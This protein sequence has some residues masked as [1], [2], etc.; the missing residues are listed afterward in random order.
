MP[1]HSALVP[2]T[3][4]M[5]VFEFQD[6]DPTY[7]HTNPDGTIFPGGI[8]V[9]KL[10]QGLSENE[11]KFIGPSG[12]IYALSV[13]AWEGQDPEKT[14]LQMVFH[15]TPLFPADIDPEL[16]R[17][18]FSQPS[19]PTSSP[20]AVTDK[21]NS[22]PSSLRVRSSPAATGSKRTSDFISCSDV[23]GEHRVKL[24]LSKT[25]S[26][27]VTADI[28]L[29]LPEITTTDVHCP[30]CNE[31]IRF[32]ETLN[33]RIQHGIDW[34]GSDAKIQLIFEHPIGVEETQIVPEG[35]PFVVHRYHRYTPTS[36]PPRQK[37]P[38]IELSIMLKTHDHLITLL[39]ERGETTAQMLLALPEAKETELAC[40]LC[41][42]KLPV[43]KPLEKYIRILADDAN[44]DTTPIELSISHPREIPVTKTPVSASL[45]HAKQ[46]SNTDASVQKHYEGY[47]G[48]V[49]RKREN[50]V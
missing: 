36:V 45:I 5:E 47:P 18:S 44:S 49:V 31:T 17:T 39:S 3:Y 26:S 43:T 25:P 12:E 38:D 15:T 7:Q 40:P 9:A 20:T 46:H 2:S 37:D 10:Q 14:L 30:V 32:S 34:W 1:L 13:A 33:K 4:T 19:T 22:S 28:L 35:S 16:R 42:E 21:G 48:F 24:Q 41:D 29:T 23:H 27:G 8:S 11:G 6:G 50:R